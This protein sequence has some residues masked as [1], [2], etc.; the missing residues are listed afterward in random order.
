MT[1]AAD[2]ELRGETSK[3]DLVQKAPS[4]VFLFC[5]DSHRPPELDIRQVL[6]DHKEKRNGNH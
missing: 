5:P 2:A 3:T 1:E 4:S 6:N